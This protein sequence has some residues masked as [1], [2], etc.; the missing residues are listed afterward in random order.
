[1][2]QI[3]RFI[4][5]GVMA[6]AVGLLAVVFAGA[7]AAQAQQSQFSSYVLPGEKVF[8]EGIA[9]QQSTGD[10][11]VGSTTDGSILQGNIARPGAEVWL[12]GATEGL[13][14]TRGMK[15]DGAGRLFVS[16]GPQ[17]LIYVFNITDK[18][19]LAR[20]ATNIQGSFINDVSVAPDGA[21]Y[22]TDSRVPNV[23]KVSADA[24]GQ[25]SLETWLVVSPTIV[26]TQ[27]FNLGGIDVSDDG[28]YMIVAQGNTGDLFRIEMSSKTITRIDLGGQSMKDA[29]GLWLD[30]QTL[31]VVRN[32]AALLVIISMS[33]DLASGTVVSSAS[34]PSFSFPTTLAKANDRLLI[35]NSQF[36]KQRSGTPP[37][38]PFTVSS[39]PAPQGVGQPQ[40]QPVLPTATLAVAPTEAPTIA[41]AAS[42]VVPSST[43]SVVPGM[44]TTGG[45]DRSGLTVLLIL[46]TMLILS[47]SL[48]LRR[49]GT[50]K[51]S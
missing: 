16:A 20:L 50:R 3:K 47:G 4:L 44:P 29:D 5:F 25:F 28:R 27:G 40:P 12:P 38:L 21:A 39:I 19:L 33:A 35:V 34:D 48:L 7:Y 30:G 26:Y 37:T 9:Y 8:P 36:D 51:S 18:K 2:T 45:S 6:M 1:M 17:G 49:T 14:G 13:T 11:Y 42:T 41:P 10:F 23:Y 24:G 43:P 22:F 31:Y 46:V 15:V 32:S